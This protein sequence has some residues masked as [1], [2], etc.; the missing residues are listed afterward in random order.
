MEDEILRKQVVGIV[1]LLNYLR[2]MF[3]NGRWC[4]LCWTLGVS[5]Q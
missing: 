3:I 4:K 5:S 2:I 1:D